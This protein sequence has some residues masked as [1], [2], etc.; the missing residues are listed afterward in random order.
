MNGNLRNDAHRKLGPVFL[1]HPVLIMRFSSICVTPHDTRSRLVMHFCSHLTRSV[2]EPA[3]QYS[4]TSWKKTK[5]RSGQVRSGQVTFPLPLA[6]PLPFRHPQSA[7]ERGRT[8]RFGS[9]VSRVRAAAV[10]AVSQL[11]L[12]QVSGSSH[13]SLSHTHH[14]RPLLRPA[15]GGSDR[16][17]AV[18][19]SARPCLRPAD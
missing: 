9:G 14:T 2:T 18:S 12:D 11:L 5:V 3:P 7:G 10:P 4:M 19:D 1:G 16:Q 8:E 15:D 17:P 6:M 13:R